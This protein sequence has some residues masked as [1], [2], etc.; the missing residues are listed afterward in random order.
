[1]KPEEDLGNLKLEFKKVKNMKEELN[2]I[3]N[4]KYEELIIYCKE[5]NTN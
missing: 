5:F 1:M 2:N 4:E 3:I